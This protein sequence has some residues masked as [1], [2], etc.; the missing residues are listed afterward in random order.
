[1]IQLRIDFLSISNFHKVR[2]ALFYCTVT[3]H[4]NYVKTAELAFSS[5]HIKACCHIFC[6]TFCKAVLCYSW[7]ASYL[8]H[9][10]YISVSYYLQYWN[11]G[12]MVIIKHIHVHLAN[13][14]HVL[15]DLQF[16]HICI[17]N[18][19]DWEWSNLVN[20]L[21]IELA[22]SF[23]TKKV[24]WKILIIE[25]GTFC[26]KHLKDQQ[27]FAEFKKRFL[28]SK[29]ARQILEP[30]KVV[31]CFCDKNVS[32]ENYRVWVNLFHFGNTVYS[33]VS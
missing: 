25:P 10:L 1:M 20:T 15:T 32:S 30:T 2:L 8:W 11:R 28:D 4:L 17:S 16:Y 31:I 29:Y 12:S 6:N 22:G 24:C 21:V 19:F 9:H 5:H 33:G 3:R 14:S 7:V 26:S 13:P 23:L 27:S 18:N